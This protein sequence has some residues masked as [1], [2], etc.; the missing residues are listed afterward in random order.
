MKKVKEPNWKNGWKLKGR[1]KRLKKKVKR[2]LNRSSLML[3]SA[4][5][6]P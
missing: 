3:L 5:K 4:K 2:L 6:M 1:K